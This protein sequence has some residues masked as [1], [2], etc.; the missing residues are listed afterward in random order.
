MSPFWK[1]TWLNLNAADEIW[2]LSCSKNF[3]V[4]AIDRDFPEW[5]NIFI[6][7]SDFSEFRESEKSLNHELVCF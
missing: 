6:E 1:K 7:F 2:N 4:Q 5:I 3:L